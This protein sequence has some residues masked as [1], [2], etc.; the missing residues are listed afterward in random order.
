MVAIQVEMVKMTIT[1]LKDEL[2][3]RSAQT[4]QAS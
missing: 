2:R 4:S 1:Q 3:A